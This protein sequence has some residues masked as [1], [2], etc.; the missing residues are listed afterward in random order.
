M[1]SANVRR[2][3]PGLGA[4]GGGFELVDDF[5]ARAGFDGLRFGVAQ[6]QR[7]AEQF[8]GFAETRRRLGLHQR[9]Q[10]GGDFVHG[11]ARPGS[12]PCA[13]S[14]PSVLMATGNGRDDAVDGGLFEQQRLAAAGRFHLAVGDLGD[15]EFGG[16]GLGNAFEFARRSSALRKSRKESKAMGGT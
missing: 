9:A 7:G 11:L 5:L 16:D 4:S 1:S 2:F 10:F 13:S 3:R 12:W 14:E 15:L 8:H 6:I